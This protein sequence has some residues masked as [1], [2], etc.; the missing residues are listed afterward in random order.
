[1]PSAPP[2]PGSMS[3]GNEVLENYDAVFK[4]PFSFFNVSAKPWSAMDIL[5]QHQSFFH[6]KFKRASKTGQL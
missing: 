5:E 1:M 2:R 4:K 6:V 3:D